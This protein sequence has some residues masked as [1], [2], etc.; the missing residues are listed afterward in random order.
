MFILTELPV[1]APIGGI[2]GGGGKESLGF[3]NVVINDGTTQVWTNTSYLS[4]AVE[5]IQRIEDFYKSKGISIRQMTFVNGG[6]AIWET[7]RD[8]KFFRVNIISK[9][10]RKFKNNMIIAAENYDA[11]LTAS[12]TFG[13]TK[14]ISSREFLFMG[15]IKY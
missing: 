6:Y 14:L 15:S 1:A 12:Q 7:P 13:T 10:P 2:D 9:D 11:A 4:N 8:A 5:Q 3:W